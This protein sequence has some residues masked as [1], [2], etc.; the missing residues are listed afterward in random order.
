VPRGGE[1]KETRLDLHAKK[2]GLR[3][4]EKNSPRDGCYRVVER[5]RK[6][7]TAPDACLPREENRR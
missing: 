1:Q 7:A 3:G 2:G 6:G 4:R 5:K